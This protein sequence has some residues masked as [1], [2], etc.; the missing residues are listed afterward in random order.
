VDAKEFGEGVWS[1]PYYDYGGGDLMMAT[2]SVPF[3]YTNDEIGEK[4]FGGVVTADITL[5]G[6]QNII[7][8]IQFLKSGRGFLISSLGNVVTYPEIDSAND[9]TVNNVFGIESNPE[10][11]SVFK[12]MVL[13]ENDLIALRGFVE[14]KNKDRWVSYASVPAA[15]WSLGIIFH[16]YELY[17]GIHELYLKLIAIGLAGFLILGF[18]IFVI[19]GRFVKPIEK[20]AFAT[21]R[22]GAGEFDF[23]IP[24]FKSQEEISQL[25]KS[26]SI[27]QLKLKDYI[28][29]L[30]ET[31][32][33]KEKMESE[34][35][36]ANNI[37]QQMLP[38]KSAMG[39]SEDIGYYGILKPA[40]SVGG[41]LYDFKVEGDYLYFAI[42]DVAGKGIPAAL[43]MAKTLTLF[44][45]KVAGG[46]SPE[47][48]AVEINHELEQY[49][50]QSMFVTFFIGKL[51]LS[52]GKLAYTNA[53]HN[54][55]FLSRRDKDIVPFKGT[56]GI[57]L[58][59][60]ADVTYKEGTFQL[61]E[62][63]K[64]ILYTDGITEAENEV[65]DLYGEQRLEDLLNRN[66]TLAPENLS[67]MIITDV[68]SF[69][70]SAEQFDD[71]T[72]LILEYK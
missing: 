18:L 17:V 24:S 37:Q 36:I 50:D 28:R 38:K 32:A 33:Q 15:N 29:N 56:H 5:T 34:L 8:D 23:Q 55:P 16:E 10:M 42:G 49:N 47:G 68:E 41:D 4:R 13:G 19:A 66:A 71:I 40:K 26:F 69:A 12:R 46:G 27:M 30:Q 14:E 9:K 48:I 67:N 61:K 35:K 6:L 45:A 53:G 39:G 21:R 43:F 58:G 70:G 1:E 22:I 2:Y 54:Y 7:N 63:D 65:H 57:P 72:L 52:S 3:Y 11:K 62:G 20:L 31:T 64:I 44:R 25:G 59:S 51:N 60:L